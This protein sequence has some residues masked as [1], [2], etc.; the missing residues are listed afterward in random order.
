MRRSKRGSASH[1][2]EVHWGL[3][4]WPLDCVYEAR[5]SDSDSELNVAYAFWKQ[6][7]GVQL[8]PP[9]SGKTM[10]VPG[11]GVW[12]AVCRFSENPEDLGKRR[13]LLGILW[14]LQW[15]WLPGTLVHSY[16][17]C[18]PWLI[19]SW[20][21]QHVKQPSLSATPQYSL[22]WSCPSPFSEGP[23]APSPGWSDTSGLCLH[24]I[25][26]RRRGVILLRG[27]DA[28]CLRLEKREQRHCVLT[29]MA[30]GSLSLPFLLCRW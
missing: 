5:N 17:H 3:C 21:K 6:D 27:E 20:V 28:R 11:V 8:H 7:L 24:C 16:R 14:V 9:K 12:H 19:P 25:T 4:F 29:R 10:W 18:T 23:V 22:P 26:C 2:T 1:S 30:L 13:Q 15:A